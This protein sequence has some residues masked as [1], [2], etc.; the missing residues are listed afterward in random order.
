M[1]IPSG[2]TSLKYTQ[3]Y[4]LYV[5]LDKY[6]IILCGYIKYP[7]VIYPTSFSQK[8]ISPTS[9]LY[10]IS[11]LTNFLIFLIQRVEFRY[12]WH[13]ENSRK[14]SPKQDFSFPDWNFWRRYASWAT[15]YM[16][17]ISERNVHIS[18]R[19]IQSVYCKYLSELE[20]SIYKNWVEGYM[21]KLWVSKIVFL[22]VVSIFL[23]LKQFELVIPFCLFVLEVFVLFVCLK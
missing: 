19:W 10:I 5:I 13:F 11:E 1:E 22:F 4:V 2:I 20:V 12:Y 7:Q 3:L 18:G 14:C 16:Q 6:K 17:S 15:F 8:V 9:L 23:Q 21:S